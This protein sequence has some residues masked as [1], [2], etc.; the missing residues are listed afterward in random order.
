MGFGGGSSPPPPPP[1]EPEDR[2]RIDP[3]RA[4]AVS[5]TRKKRIS[6]S[7]RTGRKSGLRVDLAEG[8]GQGISTN[9]RG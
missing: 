4:G 6:L 9:T 1:P 7:K 8:S 5:E 2:S 3:D